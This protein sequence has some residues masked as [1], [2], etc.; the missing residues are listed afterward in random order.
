MK[1]NKMYRIL[2]S[3]VSPLFKI[4]Y[5]VEVVSQDNIPQSGKIILCANHVSNLDGILVV[6]T[7]SRILHILAKK[8]MFKPLT[9]WFFKGLG[10]IS[11]DRKNKDIELNEKVI[12]VLN[13]NEAICLFPEGT[14]NK[15]NDA[16]LPIKYGAISF[17]IKT[18]CD[19]LPFVIVNKYKLFR[20]SVKIVYGKPYKVTNNIEEEKNRLEVILKEMIIKEKKSEHNKTNER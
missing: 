8:E 16:L 5:R 13:S 12:N 2:K 1:K 20:K 15:S 11:V 18:N 17:A 19:I 7:S 6:C 14:I 3:I 10:L 4:L 9:S